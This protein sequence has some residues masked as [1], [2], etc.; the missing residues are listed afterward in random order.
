MFILLVRISVIMLYG[1][2]LLC[3]YLS[4]YVSWTSCDPNPCIS[5]IYEYVWQ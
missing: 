5:W 4:V 1:R 2:R 3:G